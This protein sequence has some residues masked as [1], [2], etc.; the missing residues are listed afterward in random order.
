MSECQRQ[1]LLQTIYPTV[2]G[3]V[4]LSFVLAQFVI[5]HGKS[6]AKIRPNPEEEPL[7]GNETGPGLDYDDTVEGYG[8][9][10]ANA[11]NTKISIS[12]QHF[13]ISQIEPT[14]EDGTPLGV[15]KIVLRSLGDKIRLTAEFLVLL[16][17]FSLSVSV[18][19]VKDLATEWLDSW[20]P[21]VNIALWSYL[22]VV[23][24]IRVFGAST[25]LGD[26]LP[27]LWIVST[28]AYVFIWPVSAFLFRS[29]LLGHTNIPSFYYA[30][31]ALNTLLFFLAGTIRITERQGTVFVTDAKMVPSPEKVINLFEVVSFSWI[32]KMIWDAYQA[33]MTKDSVWGLRRENYA[34]YVITGFHAM[35]STATLTRKLIRYFGFYVGLQAFWTTLDSLLVFGPTVFLKLILEYV[36]NPEGTTKAMAWLYVFGMLFMS[37]GSAVVSGRTLFLGRTIC[38][39]MKAVVIGEIYAKALRRR[40]TAP[41]EEEAKDTKAPSEEETAKGTADEVSPA[42][43]AKTEE[44]KN[45]DLGAIINLMAVDAFRIADICAYLHFFVNAVIMASV[46]IYLLYNLLGWPALAGSAMIIAMMPLNYKLTD[47]MG[48]YQKVM[49]AVTD[50]RIQ[51]LNETFQSMRIVK[52]FAWE[53]K[54]FDQV[55]NIRNEELAILFK[56]CMWWVIASATYFITPSLVTVIGFYCYT[57]IKGEVLTTPVAFT[58][59]S[60]FTLLRSPLEQFAD[61][62]SFVVQSKVSL[63]RVQ[64]FLEEE[65][66]DK[67][68]QLTSP[69][70]PDSPLIGFK[71]ATMAWST[72]SKTDFRLR[73]IDVAFKENSLNVI[74]GA[75]GSGKTSLLLA[76][77]GEMNL[78]QGKVFLP[79]SIPR[80][81]LVADPETG[82]T[83]SVA[84]CSQ[85]AWLLNATIR[86]NI[87]FASPFSEERYQK[88]IDA[89]GL[90]RDLEI[91]SAGDQTEIGEKGITL[92]GGQKQRVSLARALYSHAKYVLLDDCLSAVDSH[93][94]TH[95]YEQCITGELMKGRTCVLVS[96]NIALTMQKAGFVVV[97]DNGRIKAK[98]TPEVLFDEGHLGDEDMVKT[99]VM[100]SRTVS[101]TQLASLAKNELNTEEVDKLIVAQTAAEE[102]SKPDDGKL[103][104][105][106][107]KSDGAVSLDVYKKYI[108]ALGGVVFASVVF[109]SLIFSQ[110]VSFMQS[111][112]VRVW[113]LAE[114]KRGQAVVMA[115]FTSVFSSANVR[116]TKTGIFNIDWNRPLGGDTFRI[117]GEQ[118]DTMY[119]ILIY[120]G[121]GVFYTVVSSMR[122]ALVYWGGLRASRQMFEKTLS[123]VM[124]AKLRFFDSTPVGRIMN[125]FSRDIEEIDQE[126]APYA[127][128]FVMSIIQCLWTLGLICFITPKFL[129][130]AALIAFLYYEVGVFYTSSSR[131]LKRF[132]SITRSPIHQQFTETLVGI[133]TIRAYGDERRFMRQN[134]AAID[135]NNRPFYYLWVANRWLAF[136][137]DLIGAVISFFASAFVLLASDSI[138]AGLAGLSLSYAI[139]FTQ[140]SLWVVRFYANIEMSMNAVERFLE[141]SDLEQE[142]PAEI[143]ET[144]P[145]ASWPEKGVIEVKDVSLRYAPSLP[146]VIKNVTFDVEANMKIG[147][148]GRTGAGKST[149]ITAFFR[150]LDPETGSIKIDGVDITT[151]GLK[152]LRQALTIIPQ[153]P[154][155]FT[156]TIRTNLDPFGT[157]SDAQMFE[158]LRRV[159]LITQ[160][161][162][163]ESLN[164]TAAASDSEVT[165]NQNKFLSLD[166]K[167]TEGGENLSQGQRQLVCLARSLLK[168]PK[169][170]L[171]DEATASI[172]YK[173]DAQIQQ[174]IRQEFSQSTILT[175]AHRL[176]SIID[177]DRILVMDAGEVVEYADPYTLIIDKNS[178]FRSLCND[179]GEVDVLIQLAKEA[180]VA[181]KTNSRN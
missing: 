104:Q 118:H 35:R 102:V 77:L 54:I 111:W 170:I 36:A 42:P 142:P 122:V 160:A 23:G 141:Y 164:S 16:V 124:R 150:F 37:L 162:L 152:T 1:R 40:I 9:T 96:H 133:T 65:D 95:I 154:T 116:D 31:F 134:L 52:F 76:L 38:V 61:M 73:D 180:F 24:T 126:L 26:R 79:G 89:C 4:S 130:I 72:T 173:S 27:N 55:V 106:E 15:T 113:A 5:R 125:R 17:Q 94:S 81:E 83:E 153:D 44:R 178:Q 22:L 177:Y 78:I 146:L 110:F 6:K 109:F 107:T 174:T 148:V 2:V 136:R 143:L 14:K 41:S 88:V 91:L 69:R 158:A 70:S 49:L 135:E 112:W 20:T 137:S 82:L 43:K 67:Y 123:V 62:L 138:D 117:Q 21:L 120:A 155:L 18:F 121:I 32:D 84:Y 30:Q 56:R 99:S 92:S 172:D 167:I 166:A 19:F 129:V 13:D 127:D 87:V 25:G 60:L 165:E 45:A 115:S 39:R 108:I 53:D 144:Q 7:L 151:I 90:K 101:S 159:N 179:T 114:D 145:P 85:S 119:Y 128:Y 103:V 28:A 59:L 10:G 132:E 93:T 163:T 8:S 71:D 46:A 147:I 175:I 58:A 168:S 100:G 12:E 74:I 33:P 57:Q 156:G 64:E 3:F 50:R 105:E 140:S 48:S 139:A 29:A 86:E 66:C 34:Y 98:G 171:L 169:V 51:K 157:Y 176:R 161:E 11:A 149:I 131:E 181:R 68:E 47:M 63:D 75:T 97:M 80:D